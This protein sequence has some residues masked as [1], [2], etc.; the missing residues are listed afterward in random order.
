MLENNAY[1]ACDASTFYW[2]A[3]ETRDKVE[4]SWRLD[5]LIG[6]NRRADEQSFTRLTDERAIREDVSRV[7]RQVN[8]AERHLENRLKYFKYAYL[9]A[10]DVIESLPHG[11]LRP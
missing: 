2:I 6:I 8:R 3:E 4:G 1:I 10:S 5:G 11:N 9:L 7:T